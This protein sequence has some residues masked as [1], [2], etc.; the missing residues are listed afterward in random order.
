[1]VIRLPVKYLRGMVVWVPGGV[2]SV[3]LGRPERQLL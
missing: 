1:M 3:H 2:E